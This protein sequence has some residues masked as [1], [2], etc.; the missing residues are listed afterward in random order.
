M[1]QALSRRARS[2]DFADDSRLTSIIRRRLPGNSDAHDAC[3][4]LS[5]VLHIGERL[6]PTDISIIS[7]VISG[8]NLS[9]AARVLA[10]ERPSYRKYISKVI[11]TKFIPI[12]EELLGAKRA[13]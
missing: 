13:K 10:P 3:R 6:T 8:G 1:E 2:R 7:A 9:A 11:R 5:L 4:I 12:V